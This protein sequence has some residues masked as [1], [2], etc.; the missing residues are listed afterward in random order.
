MA[1][2]VTLAEHF[3]LEA[4]LADA[5]ALFDDVAG[6]IG[7]IPGA[8]VTGRNEDG[9]YAA[10]IG[11]QYGEASVHF[12]GVVRLERTSP[13][14][15]RVRAEG[16]DGLRSVRADGEMRLAFGE[17]GPERTAVDLVAS[18]AFS[19]VLAPLARSATRM[20]GPQLMKSFAGCLAARASA[21]T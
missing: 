5:L 20:V 14:S 1:S 10:R 8:G 2:V 12:T 6:V 21:K 9:G 11:A 13:T 18:F 4:T 19:G 15:L 7:C 16:Q 3:T 17:E